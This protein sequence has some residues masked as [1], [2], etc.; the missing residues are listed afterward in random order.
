V[1][2]GW[3]LVVDGWR[4]ENIGW[5]SFKMAGSSFQNGNEFFEMTLPFFSF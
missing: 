5:M 2:V 4:P 3:W 1:A